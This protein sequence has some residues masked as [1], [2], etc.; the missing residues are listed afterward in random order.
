MRITYDHLHKFLRERLDA[1]GEVDGFTTEA[2]LTFM[3]RHFDCIDESKLRAIGTGKPSVVVAHRG[4]FC[5]IAHDGVIGIYISMPSSFR[6]REPGVPGAKW[7]TSIE[8]AGPNHFSDM[9]DGRLPY[10]LS[11]GF[12]TDLMGFISGLFGK[13]LCNCRKCTERRKV[14]A[15]S[16][17]SCSGRLH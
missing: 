3:N 16:D 11:P 12:V 2:I 6:A 13:P 5:K 17:S 15:E 1:D 10:V 14:E 7:T 9:L 8:E 4:I